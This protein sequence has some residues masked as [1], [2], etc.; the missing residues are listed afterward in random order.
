MGQDQTAVVTASTAPL[1]RRPARAFCSAWFHRVISLALAGAAAAA[2]GYLWVQ[3][4][5]ET[6]PPSVA[7]LDVY[8]LFVDSTP[9]VVTVYAGGEYAPWLATAHAIRTDTLTRRGHR[10]SAGCIPRES[11]QPRV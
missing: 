9:V 7:P 1:I 4:W 6:T 5:L 3:T 2:G 8:A 10:Q 11:S